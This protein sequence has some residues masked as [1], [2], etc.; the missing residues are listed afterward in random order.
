LQTF[1][2]RQLRQ[3]ATTRWNLANSSEDVPGIASKC[4]EHRCAIRAGV[5]FKPSGQG[6]EVL[7]LEWHFA[8]GPSSGG[9]RSTVEASPLFGCVFDG[10][11]LGFVRYF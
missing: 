8:C 2:E 3:S 10:I 4:L 7:Q 9:S 1:V 11:G 6:S 5:R